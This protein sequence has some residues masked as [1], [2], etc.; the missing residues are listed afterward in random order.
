MKGRHS[1]FELHFK[2]VQLDASESTLASANIRDNSVIHIDVP[3]ARSAD[4]IPPQAGVADLEELSLVKVYTQSSQMAFSYWIPRRTTNTFASVIFKYWRRRFKNDSWQYISDLI[5]WTGMNDQGDGHLSGH[6]HDHWEKLSGFLNRRDCTG[7][8]KNEKLCES[9]SSESED[10]IYDDEDLEQ[11]ISPL[12]LKIWL[13]G[14][15]ASKNKSGKNL[16]RVSRTFLGCDK[17]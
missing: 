5:P 17:C 9:G 16:S 2:N 3:E 7:Q 13:G 8:L 14:K 1:K 6:F 12:V 10:D 4:A 15:P 11:G